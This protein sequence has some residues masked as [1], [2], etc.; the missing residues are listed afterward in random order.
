M[1][2]DVVW[3]CIAWAV[4]P[5]HIGSGVEWLKSDY[6]IRDHR[7]CRFD[8]ASVVLRM[9]PRRREAFERAVDAGDLQGADRVLKE[10][11]RDADILERIPLG[12]RSL[13][14]LGAAQTDP[15]RW[16][17]VTAF[18]RTGGRPFVPGSSIKGAIRTALLSTTVGEKGVEEG[19]RRVQA[20]GERAPDRLEEW[21]FA[22]DR[23][24]I[25]QDPFRFLQ[26]SDAVL[27]AGATRIDRVVNWHPQGGSSDRIQIHVERLVARCDGQGPPRFSFE[28]RIDAGRLAEARRR[29]GDRVPGFERLT[30]DVL[31]KSVKDFYWQRLDWELKTFFSDGG[32]S[33]NVLNWFDYMWK[34]SDGTAGRLTHRHMRGVRR[35]LLLRLGRFGQFESKSVDGLRSGVIRLPDNRSRRAPAGSTRNLVEIEWKSGGTVLAPMGWVL[36]LVQRE[37]ARDV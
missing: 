27:P 16:G 5:V 34:K 32:E 35:C 23:R 6:T 14:E 3:K 30:P 9:E 37:V 15:K 7:L 1:K 24:R 26:V 19:R 17:G 22:Y 10:A 28:I 2:G 33:Q 31:E 4:T 12:P 11:V 36:V 20:A 29:D 25:E 21:A 8:P 18:V 13:R